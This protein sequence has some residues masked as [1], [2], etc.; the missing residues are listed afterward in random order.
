[1]DGFVD[2]PEVG[3]AKAVLRRLAA[4]AADLIVRVEAGACEKF[5]LE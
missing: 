5:Q 4:R 3:E 1:M 2:R